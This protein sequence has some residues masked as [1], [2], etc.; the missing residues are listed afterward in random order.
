MAPWSLAGLRRGWNDLFYAPRDTRVLDVMRIGTRRPREPTRTAIREA[1]EEYTR[2]P[3]DVIVNRKEP[4][5][6]SVS[7]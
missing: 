2:C 1:H 5:R 6:G 4:F 7:G 3:T